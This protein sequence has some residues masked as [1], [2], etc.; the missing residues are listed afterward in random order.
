MGW[1]GTFHLQMEILGLLDASS[2]A[3]DYVHTHK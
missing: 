2:V 3:M 1:L